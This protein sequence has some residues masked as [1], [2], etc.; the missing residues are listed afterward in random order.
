MTD[1]IK[2][3]VFAELLKV[4]CVLYADIALKAKIC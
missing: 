1:T 3:F 2:G 4:N